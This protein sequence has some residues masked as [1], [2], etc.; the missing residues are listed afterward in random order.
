MKPA[1]G[2]LAEAV[3]LALVLAASAVMPAG[4]PL[5]LYT[6]VSEFLATYLIHCPA[7]YVVGSMVG[8]RFRRMRVGSTTLARSLPQRF[9]A[10]AKLFPVLTLSTAKDSLKGVPKKRIALMY[11]AGFVASVSAALIIAAAATVV[12]SP[13]YA[14][15]AWALALAYLAFDLAFSPKSG[16]LARARAAYTEC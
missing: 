9:S 16:D 4:V 12:E 15:L 1:L 5:G 14:L 11:K 10:V 2:V 13:A 7:H 6:L 3:V 8:I